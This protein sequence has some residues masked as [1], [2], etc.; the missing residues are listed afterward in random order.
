MNKEP[1]PVLCWKEN[2]KECA[3]LSLREPSSMFILMWDFV[4]LFFSFSNSR[5]CRRKRPANPR[6]QHWKPNAPEY[7]L[8]TWHRPRTRRQGDRW[9]DSSPAEAKRIRTWVSSTK[10]H[11]CNHCLQFRKIRLRGKAEELFN[12]FY[13]LAIA[14][15]S[16]MTA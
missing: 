2:L 13:S 10:K 3:F 5:I 7:G 11:P 9:A 1:S 6:K 8:D 12:K 16:K 15:C 14:H 4:F